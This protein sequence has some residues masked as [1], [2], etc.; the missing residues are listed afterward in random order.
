M[1]YLY[2]PS[3]RKTNMESLGMTLMGNLHFMLCCANNYLHGYYHNPSKKKMP[4]LTRMYIC[5]Y[6]YGKHVPL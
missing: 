4:T 3:K 2:T 1:L 6:V 5:R